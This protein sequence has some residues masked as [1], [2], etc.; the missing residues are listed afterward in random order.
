MKLKKGEQSATNP[1]ETTAPLT[2]EELTAQLNSLKEMMN[3]TVDSRKRQAFERSKTV[4]GSAKFSLKYMPDTPNKVV[5]AWR[6]SKD[7]VANNGKIED[8]RMELTYADGTKQEI[9]YV[10]FYRVLRSTPKLEAKRLYV[11]NGGQ[12]ENL[13][14]VRDTQG[15]RIT[16]VPQATTEEGTW[17]GKDLSSTTPEKFRVVVEFEGNDYDVEVTYTNA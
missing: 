11:S 6:T 12:E 10:D 13:S 2:I 15:N 14:Y 9:A 3:A 1:A 17:E 8:Q 7:F 4:Q 5:V 16:V